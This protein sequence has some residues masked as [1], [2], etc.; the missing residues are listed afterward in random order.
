MGNFFRWKSS[1]YPVLGCVWH[2]VIFP[3]SCNIDHCCVVS[4]HLVPAVVKVIGHKVEY[5]QHLTQFLDLVCFLDGVPTSWY[6]NCQQK[7]RLAG[8][9]RFSF[10]F[11]QQLFTKICEPLLVFWDGSSSVFSTRILPIQVEA[12]KSPLSQKWYCMFNKNLNVKK[13]TIICSC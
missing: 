7:A 2:V 10:E 3:I 4:R 9:G 6:S 11:I 1:L 12:I 5:V 8:L 13:T